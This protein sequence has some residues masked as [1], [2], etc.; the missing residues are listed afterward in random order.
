MKPADEFRPAV[1]WAFASRISLVLIGPNWSQVAGNFTSVWLHLMFLFVCFFI[2][3]FVCLFGNGNVLDD[4]NWIIIQIM[5]FHRWLS[6]SPLT[7]RMQSVRIIPQ[8]FHGLVVCIPFKSLNRF[9]LNLKSWFGWLG[10]IQSSQ[11]GGFLE[12]F[13]A[14]FFN[15]CWIDYW[16]ADRSCWISTGFYFGWWTLVHD[17]INKIAWNGPLLTSS[18]PAGCYV[19]TSARV[20]PAGSLRH[21]Q[22]VHQPIATSVFKRRARNKNIS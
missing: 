12:R 15:I 13:L 20:L 14:G 17:E 5:S 2:C 9:D 19:V 8:C 16:S 21:G 6:F 18:L 4:F 7:G 10:W 1:K 22:K 11:F 3:F